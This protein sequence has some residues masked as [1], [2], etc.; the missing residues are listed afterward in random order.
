MLYKS[1]YG[2]RASCARFHEH[3]SDKLLKLGFRPSKADPDLWI[4]DLD[5]HYEYI[6]T[7]VDDLLIASKNP[8]EIIDYLKDTYVLKGVGIPEY[9]L[10]ANVMRS[11]TEWKCES[12]EWI[13]SAKTYTRNVITKFEEL[14]A[15]GRSPYSFR[16]FKTPMDKDYHAELEDSPLLDAE[17]HTRYR[18]M[19]G[20][21]NWA[22]TLGR[23]DI[24]YAVTTL[25]R[26]AHAPREG[27]MKA[28][29][30][31]F[32]YLKKFQKGKLI[33]DPYLPNH[34]AYPYDD[35]NNWRDLYPDTVEE[36]PPGAPTPKGPKVRVT[37][38]VDA[39][40]A[41]D[42]VTCRSVT[43]II[44]MI[45]NTVV[46]TYSKRQATVESSTYGSELVAARIATDIAIEIR[47]ILHMLG[48]EIDG[49]MKP[50]NPSVGCQLTINTLPSVCKW[51]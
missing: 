45:N 18:A 5:T 13:I 29:L 17:Y 39:D 3:L 22:V 30:R 37:I 25:A 7:Y 49:S 10:G 40:H 12:I 24:Q 1:I 31:V 20:S 4:K 44:V 46:K 41:R 16:E 28:V 8:Q 42:K 51:L 21:L 15:E 2:A 9:Y 23:F 35:L 48:V 14:M 19:I 26:Y 36:I 47:C 32:G 33:I 38:W 27:H 34:Q 11:P 43:G 6:G 50:S